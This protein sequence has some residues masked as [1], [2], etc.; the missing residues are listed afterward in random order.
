[1]HTNGYSIRTLVA[2]IKKVYISINILQY[3]ISFNDK[4]TMLMY[5]CTYTKHK[6]E[7]A[8]F[9]SPVRFLLQPLLKFVTLRHSIVHSRC[10]FAFIYAIRNFNAV[11]PEFFDH[12]SVKTF[13]VN[14]LYSHD[15]VPHPLLIIVVICLGSQSKVE[16]LECSFLK[17]NAINY[18]IYILYYTALS[19]EYNY[20]I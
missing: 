14:F 1:M 5:I 18:F 20:N 6:I 3:Q 19:R 12:H 11:L 9:S 16:F 8:S 15:S 17:F 2:F 4:D 7:T 13:D 10:V